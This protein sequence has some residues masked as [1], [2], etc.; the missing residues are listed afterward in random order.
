MV[1]LSMIVVIHDLK[2]PGLSINAIARKMGLDRK[3]VR[4]Y[5]KRRL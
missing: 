5:L 4:N 1:N 3:T 2:R